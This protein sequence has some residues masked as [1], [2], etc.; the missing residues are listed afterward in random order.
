MTAQR[1]SKERQGRRIS[2]HIAKTLQTEIALS[3]LVNPRLTKAQRR[4][5][6]AEICR[7]SKTVLLG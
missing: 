6:Y 4:R 7:R 2:G 3:E 5:I 1:K